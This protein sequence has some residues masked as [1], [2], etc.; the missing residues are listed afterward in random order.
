[1]TFVSAAFGVFVAGIS[2]L[3]FCVKKN[4]RWIV[5]LLGSY[6]FYWMSS[7]AFTVVLLL[8][9][10]V[11][12][13]IG[14]MIDTR[15]KKCAIYLNG[16]SEITSEERKAYKQN[17]K[18]VNKHILIWGVLLDLSMLLLLKYF[19]FFSENVCE[20]FRWIGIPVAVPEW[21]L[22][23]PIG[24]S[25]YTL[26]AIAYMTD[27][28]RGKYQADK[29]P[30]KFMLFMSY[31]PQ[32]VQ[33]PIAR[34][35]HL[36]KQLYEGHEFDYK[37]CMFGLQLIL[38]GLMKKL[39][40]ADR[41]A[42]PVNMVF[43]HYGDYNGLIV[44]F[45]AFGY[46][47]QVYA[48]FSGGMDIARG[49]SQIW[50]IDLQLNFKQPYFARSIE[51]FWRRWHITLGAWM[52]DYV[53][54]PLSLSKISGSIGKKTRK[55]FGNNV[56]KKIPSFIAMFIVYFL[57]G[58]WHGPEWKYIAYG[59]WNGIFIMSGILLEEFYSNTKKKLGIQEE[60]YS[61]KAFQTFRTIVLCSV[62]RFFSRADN[63]LAA[64]LMIASTLKGFS[65][66]AFLVDRTLINL[67]LDTADWV[68]LCIMLLIMLGVDTAHEK[69]IKIRQAIAEQG[70]V[71]RW[72][73]YYAAI[74]AVIIFGMYGSG[75]DSASFIYQQF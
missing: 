1:M 34:H 65:N 72:L 68:V 55:I 32:I 64:F 60:R 63:L 11:T 51:E 9:T 29:N 50:G 70:I 5:L 49:V 43:N 38:W 69:G 75:Y 44:L 52:K 14:K 15:N 66:I 25:F 45:A 16:H 46:G 24:L 23:I 33:G 58:F 54:Y 40:I 67:G 22:L 36:A 4:Y 37:R 56:G 71:F 35:D 18:K 73:I 48:D 27:V 53:F 30:F 17:H 12:F 26:Q 39:V 20:L 6:F 28:Y 19:H 8:M 31:F 57:V 42:I 74:F 10:S 21:N 61:W 59:I 7:R 13:A 47:L 62:G 3:Y 41:L 2:I